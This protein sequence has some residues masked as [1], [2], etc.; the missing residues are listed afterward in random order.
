MDDKVKGKVTM[1]LSV[2][3]L[4]FFIFWLGAWKELSRQ[5]RLAA[6]KA[7]LSMELEEKNAKLEKE[8]ADLSGQ[9]KDA[10]VKLSGEKAA[11]EI[12]KKTLSQEQVAENALKIE[13]E[14]VTRL[15]EKLENSSKEVLDVKK[16]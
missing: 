6:D 15:N 8:K 7:A 14:R 11:H 16:E 10:Q 4:I 12:T 2:V 9:L 5:K 13:L 1:I 3:A